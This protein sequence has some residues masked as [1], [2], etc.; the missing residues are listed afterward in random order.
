VLLFL[1][2]FTFVKSECLNLRNLILPKWKGGGVVWI[3]FSSFRGG[4]FAVVL[5]LASRRGMGSV[6]SCAGTCSLRLVDVGIASGRNAVTL[7]MAAVR[8]SEAFA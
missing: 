2:F 3:G 4:Y 8:D 5:V 7:M 1:K 6:R